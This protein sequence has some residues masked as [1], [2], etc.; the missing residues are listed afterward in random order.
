MKHDERLGPPGIDPLSDAA[1]T[2]IERG[3]WSRVD[4][5]VAVSAPVR[6]PAWRRWR[7][8]LA[9]LALVA[10]VVII[11]GAFRWSSERPPVGEP[12]RV[13]SG[14][15]PSAISFGDVHIE[16]DP[17][18]AL[19]MTHEAGQPIAS[20]E[21]GAV[22]FTVAP[23]GD[24]PPVLVRAGDATVRVIGTR[25]RV[26]RS[27]EHVGVAVAHGVVD[28]AYRGDTHAVAASQRWSS[29]TPSEVET[30]AAARPSALPVATPAS[31]GSAAAVASA[32]RHA[33]DAAVDRDHA[34]YDR[35]TALEAQ[36]SELAIAGYLALSHTTGPWAGPAL[37]AAARLATDRGDRRAATLLN[38]YL[39]RFP[40]G[41]NAAD[42]RTLHSRLAAEPPGPR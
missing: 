8:A 26:A 5:D 29:D 17:D 16:L 24:R 37:F 3:L 30:E 20:L 41:A 28:I 42:A 38:A 13:V 22:W 12:S 11:V 36:S 23:R 25:F 32:P 1:W 19:V 34:E 40:E 4:A 21:R 10:T 15:S 7:I 2:R 18:T 14:A 9:P 35:L 31:S 39:Q 27:D 6:S 33:A